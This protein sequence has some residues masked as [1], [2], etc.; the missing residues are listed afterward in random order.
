MEVK[1]V[2]ALILIGGEGTR[3]RPL[4]INTLKCTVPIVN[5]PFFEYQFEL[6]KKH[7]INEVILSICHMP[8][9][10]KRA[11]GNGAKYGMKIRYAAEKE[12][13]GTGG[14]VRNAEKYLDDITVVLN[15]DILTDMDLT[16]M[17][18]SHKKA[19][20]IATLALHEVE[21]PASYG[22][23]ETQETGRI[24]NFLEKPGPAEAR[25]KWINAG[26][27]IFEKAVLNYIPKGRNC[28]LEREIFPGML[29]ADETLAAFKPDAYWLDIGR[30]DKYFQANFD[31]L[32]KRFSPGTQRSKDTQ[33]EIVKGRNSSIDAMAS[34]NGSICVGSGCRI[35]KST[36]NT[37]V[38]V[39]DN[40]RIGNGCRIERSIIWDN[41]VIGDNVAIK[42]SIVG[43][44]CEIQPNSVI[45]E[46]VL[47]DATRVTRYSRLGH[48]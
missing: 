15:G 19:G 37:K 21:D 36:F 17:E 24:L 41:T 18:A 33:W 14:A 16:A 9:E 11:I 2:K 28:S 20:A 32:E 12:P 6:L 29:A 46:A 42:E 26:I 47:G 44:K 27:Y 8:G 1:L 23:V 31:V 38:I 13:L 10:V 35:G 4:T 3:L 39:G 5:R 7:G 22:L 30:I 25:S 45:N 48:G 43:K 40:C 34:L